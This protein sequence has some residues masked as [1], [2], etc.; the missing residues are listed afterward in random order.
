MNRGYDK[1]SGSANCNYLLLIILI[2]TAFLKSNHQLTGFNSVQRQ[3]RVWQNRWLQMPAT[4]PGPGA[5]FA[6]QLLPSP[7]AVGA[8]AVVS[9]L[10]RSQL[11]HKLVQCKELSLYHQ[12]SL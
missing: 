2:I 5:K 6:S 8:T 3:Q 11:R 12:S 1:K 9:D 10:H 7:S 4:L